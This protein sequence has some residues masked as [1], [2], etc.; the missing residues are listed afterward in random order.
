V[1][2]AEH[3]SKG[4]MVHARDQSDSYLPLARFKQQ[5]GMGLAIRKYT[6]AKRGII[7]TMHLVNLV[8]CFQ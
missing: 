4:E 1:V 3:H 7:A 8:L 2:V 5:P 6:L